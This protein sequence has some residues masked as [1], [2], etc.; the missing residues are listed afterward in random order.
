MTGVAVP[1]LQVGP[2]RKLSGD[3]DVV[4]GRIRIGAQ[5]CLTPK[6]VLSLKTPP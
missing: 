2:L 1:I 5:I 4:N 3:P 6:P